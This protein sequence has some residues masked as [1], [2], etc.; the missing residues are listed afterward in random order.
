[1]ILQLQEA[2]FMGQLRSQ[3]RAL[4]SQKAM[5][6]HLGISPQYL[7]DLLHERREPSDRILK[8]FGLRWAIVKGGSSL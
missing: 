8:H 6:K 4:G 5:A 2:D 1:M 7:S 3:L